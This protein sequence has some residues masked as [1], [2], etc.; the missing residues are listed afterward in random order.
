MFARDLLYA[1]RTLRRSPLFAVTAMLTI[2]LGIG[3]ATAIFSVANAVLIQPL[4]YR[5]PAK[6]AFVI[7]DLRARNVKD[8]PFS[9][10]D[11]LDLRTQTAS[12]FE[13]VGAVRTN[14][15]TVP[16]EDGAPEQI[17]FGVASTNFLHMMG[18]GVALGRGFTDADGAPQ[19]DPPLNAAPGAAPPA[20]LPAMVMLSHSYWQRRF[21]GRADILGKPLPGLAQGNNVVVGV[22]SPGFEL[23]FATDANVERLPDLWLAA[24][25][26]YD[27]ANRNNVQWR[28]IARLRKGLTV[29]TAQ[30]SA[31]RYAAEMRKGNLISN[32]AGFAVRVE[33]MQRHIAQ[34]VRPALITLMGAV[35]FLLLIACAN[36]ANLLLVRAV[37][38]QRELAVR[39]R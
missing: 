24:R 8:F 19:P 26:P 6:L 10:A 33:P 11:F 28:V 38:R 21:G 22:L 14:R 34:A 29:Q 25:I 16:R 39:L 9:N 32:T 2:A 3:A 7:E 23:L 36:V 15:A 27:T 12:V 35:V 4:P 37:A 18:A 30:S 13:E 1:A 20:R 5:D 17:R 31:D